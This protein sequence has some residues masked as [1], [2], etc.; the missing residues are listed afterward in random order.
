LGLSLCAVPH[1]GQCRGTHV[2]LPQ[3]RL[4]QVGNRFKNSDTMAAL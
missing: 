3:T 2:V 1:G 4:A